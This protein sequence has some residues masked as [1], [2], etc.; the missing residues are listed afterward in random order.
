MSLA[1]LKRKTMN[2]N[3]RMSPISGTGSGSL[4]FAL[5][6]TRRIKGV[7]GHTNLGPKGNSN[8]ISCCSEDNSVIKPSVKN[9]KGM[10]SVRYSGI[11]HGQNPRSVVQP[12]PDYT[13]SQYIHAL[14]AECN[15][16]D[17][18]NKDAK[19]HSKS[20]NTFIGGK[21]KF[22]GAY[23]KPAPGPIS[24]SE[25]IKGRYLRNN[26]YLRGPSCL[27]VKPAMKNNGNCS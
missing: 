1:T 13:Q 17:D 25:Y 7:V 26:A 14:H 27:Q 20:S 6:G 16:H 22:T 2:G 3:P 18:L 19:C 12:M 4:G 10:I 24:Q 23:T 8:G 15:T 5:N 11:L 21:N 9:T